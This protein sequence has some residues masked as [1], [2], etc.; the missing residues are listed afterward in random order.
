[1]RHT[2]AMPCTGPRQ[3]GIA[4]VELAILLPVLMVMLVGVLFYSRYFWHYTV[5]QKAARDGA[6]LLASTPKLEMT[7]PTPVGQVAPAT[8]AVSIMQQEIA[9]LNPGGLAIQP[10]VMCQVQLTGSATSLTWVPCNGTAVPANIKATIF[11]YITD[12]FFGESPWAMAG[13]A[14]STV[15]ADVIVP[16]VGN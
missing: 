4:A 11:M 12:P 6:L 15:A 1:M 16:Y 13:A 9:E 3:R 8:L 2:P 7:K 14:T 5:L 10:V